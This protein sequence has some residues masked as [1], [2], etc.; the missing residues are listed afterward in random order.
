MM[1][2]VNI[3]DLIKQGETFNGKMQESWEQVFDSCR[4]RI[5]NLILLIILL[6]AKKGVFF[7]HV[8]E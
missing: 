7:L 6:H 3:E 1:T 8:T 4:P 2:E 5:K